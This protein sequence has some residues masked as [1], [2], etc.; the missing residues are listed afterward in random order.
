[1][2]PAGRSLAMSGLDVN[3]EYGDLENWYL[4]SPITI[5]ALSRVRLEVRSALEVIQI[6]RDTYCDTVANHPLPS[7]CHVL[8]EWPKSC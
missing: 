5:R 7:E 3:L 8:F 4:E 2:R 1:M 6:T